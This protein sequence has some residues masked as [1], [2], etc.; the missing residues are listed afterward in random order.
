MYINGAVSGRGVFVGRTNKLICRLFCFFVFLFLYFLFLCF[1]CF[2]VFLVFLVV[3]GNRPRHEKDRRG[4]GAVRRHLG[5]GVRR[6][7]T[8]PEREIRDGSEEGDKE[9]AAAAR[10]GEDV[11]QQFGREGQRQ[12]DRRP[13]A[14]R[15]EDGAVQG[16]RKG[17]QDEDVLEGGA[18]ARGPSGSDGTGEEQDLRLDFRARVH[19]AG[20]H[21]G[22]RGG[23]RAAFQREGEKIQQ[24]QN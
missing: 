2:F 6:G 23:D 7:T 13:Q 8:E 5:E 1:F 14:D 22:E 16:V 19:V 4:R 24:I 3:S 15:D 18:G 10:S 21:R 17:D 11:D 9:T 12:S 20:V